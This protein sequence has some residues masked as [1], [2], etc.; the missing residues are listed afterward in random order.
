MSENKI[1]TIH[2]VVAAVLKDVPAISKDKVNAHQKFKFRGIDDVY[3]HLS[4]H[5]KKHGLFSTSQI[6]WHECHE[7]KTRNGVARHALV[8]VTYSF[9]APGCLDPVKTTVIGEAIDSGDKAFGKALVYAHK[10]ALLQLFM[11]PTDDL[12]PDK[13]SHEVVSGLKRPAPEK[14]GELY[15]ELPTQ[16]KVFQN[17][18]QKHEHKLSV[19]EMRTISEKM[20]GTLMRD[21]EEKLIEFLKRYDSEE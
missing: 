16:K 11:I 20:T 7:V 8:Q 18:L 17:I 14:S 9:E 4:P 5:C 19:Q 2:E 10:Y 15:Q 1:K 6:D 21:L 12:D 13:E 3:N